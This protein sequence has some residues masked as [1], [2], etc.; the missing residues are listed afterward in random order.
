M[1]TW[2]QTTKEEKLGRHKR[3]AAKKTKDV[4]ELVQVLCCDAKGFE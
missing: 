4:Q 2:I 1:L 3:A